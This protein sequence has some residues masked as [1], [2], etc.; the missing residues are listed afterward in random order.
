MQSRY[1]NLQDRACDHVVSK[2]FRKLFEP[3]LGRI[4]LHRFRGVQ[5]K[6]PELGV[7]VVA[8]NE[9]V[10]RSVLHVFR[11]SLNVIAGISR[12]PAILGTRVFGESHPFL[13]R[14]T[15]I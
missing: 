3:W 11:C 14:E 8:R 1:T 10:R 9:I 6:A 4:V 5:E 15:V 2:I 7:E 13:Y 12:S